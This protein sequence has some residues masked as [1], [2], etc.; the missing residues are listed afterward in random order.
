MGLSKKL[1]QQIL[2]RVN[3]VEKAVALKGAE[4][5]QY[6]EAL[7]AVHGPR[8]VRA[9]D[10]GF[11]DRTWYH[12][13]TVDIPE[14]KNEAK[15][16]STNA[17]S[18][19]KGFF[20]AEDP[21]TASDYA[22]LAREKGVTRGAIE[23]AR[24]RGTRDAY[25]QEMQDK[26]GKRTLAFGDNVEAPNWQNSMSKEEAARYKELDDAYN[27]ASDAAIDSTVPEKLG[28]THYQDAESKIYDLKSRAEQEAKRQKTLSDWQKA[29]KE[30]ADWLVQGAQRSGVSVDEWIAEKTKRLQEPIK[31][32]SKAEI[33]AAE[34]AYKQ[35]L[36]DFAKSNEPGYARK[37]LNIDLERKN[38]PY[39]QAI[40][41][42]IKTGEDFNT[43]TGQNVIPVRLKGDK[44]SIHVKDYKGQGYRDSTYA[45][46]MTQAQADGKNAV[47]FRN[48]YDPADPHNRVKQDIAAVFEPNQV[49]STNA[50]FDPRFKDSPNILALDGQN[51]SPSLAA[52]IASRVAQ[53]SAKAVMPS[54]SGTE[55]IKRMASDAAEFYD[56]KVQQPVREVLNK[57]MRGKQESPT[58]ADLAHNLT[59]Q[60]DFSPDKKALDFAEPALALGMS[61]ATDPSNF[62]PGSFTK[63]LVNARKISGAEKAVGIAEKAVLAEKKVNELSRTQDVFNGGVKTAEAADMKLNSQ[64]KG[65]AFAPKGSVMPGHG[66]YLRSIGALKSK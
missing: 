48:T 7:D 3:S 8:D 61:V 29:K 21:S 31:P 44:E 19:K 49:R 52:N 50:A 58:D 65:P 11:G 20:F 25:M 47:L 5:A 16:L 42:A 12:G 60:L 34:K 32:A 66:E 41:D 64:L 43:S 13:S 51:S 63:N 46:E 39:R 27:A 6:L 9:K 14:F 57:L 1:A 26:Y 28:Y 22:D 17:Q 18:A 37:I 2:E 36:V 23:E 59:Q 33:I 10:L 54:F 4:K 62:I 24:A 40:L 56:S 30:N 15:G 38:H 45:D 53:R 35:S 55:D